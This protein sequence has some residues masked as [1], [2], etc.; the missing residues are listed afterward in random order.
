MKAIIRNDADRDKF[1]AFIKQV[2]LE[3]PYV[4]SFVVHRKKRSLN[5]NRLLYLWL[6]CIKTET[7]NSVDALYQYFC[8]KYL[9]WNAELVFGNE[10]LPKGGSSKL[11]TKE[12]TD[13]LDNIN[14]EMSGQGIYLPY[15]GDIGYDEFYL[16]YGG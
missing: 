2:K 1:I 5:Q 3:K 7:G 15:P 12:F 11:N 9:P 4:A 13:F 16:Q 14:K 10:V 6:N 8:E